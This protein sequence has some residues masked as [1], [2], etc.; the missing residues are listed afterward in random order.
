MTIQN[1]KLKTPQHGSAPYGNLTMLRYELKFDAKGRL[2]GGT[3]GEAVKQ[4]DE[5]ILDTLPAGFA[6]ERATVFNTTSSGSA[7]TA[8]LGYA[9]QDGTEV[10]QSKESLL[11][12]GTLASQ[13]KVHSTNSAIVDIAKPANLVL[14][15]GGA[16]SNITL[17]VTVVGEARGG[18]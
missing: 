17:Q 1:L 2:V 8:T 13:P 16:A 5:I 6:I 3:S 11:K 12:A 10:A 18:L 9:Y 4:S 15:L 14:T 7:P